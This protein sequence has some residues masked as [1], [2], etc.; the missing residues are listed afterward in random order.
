MNVIWLGHGS[1]G[2]QAAAQNYFRKD[3]SQLTLA[4]CA[5]IAGL[6]QA[7]SRVNPVVA[8]GPA[9]ERMLH[10]LR[11]MERQ[12]WIS[13]AELEA[14]SAEELRIAP[15]RDLLGDHV[16]YYTEMVRQEIVRRFDDAEHGRSWLDRG[17]AVSMAV[18]PALQR[19]ASRALGHALE[20]LARRQGFPGPLGKLDR[21]TFFERNARFV[22]PPG[23]PP[24]PA[25]ARLLG[26]VA[27]VT[28]EAAQIELGS[29][30]AGRLTLA[31][32]KWAGPYTR[33]P[34]GLDKAGRRSAKV[35]F[36]P[37]AGDLTEVLTT[38]D[39]VWV[40][41][42]GGAA[43]TLELA[44]VPVPLVEGAVVSRPHVTGAV[45][46]AVGGW[47][48]DRSQVQRVGALRQTGSVMKPIVYSKAYD[49][50]LPP[51]A[52]FSGAPFREGKYNPTGARTKDD[53][54]VWEALAHSENS[55]SL[56]V[57]QYVLNHTS[58]EDYAA[59]GARLGLTH[60][61]AGY[62]SEVLGTDQTPLGVADV[63][64]TFALGGAAPRSGFIRKVV[65][66]DGRVLLRD[67]L[68]LD[69]RAT[70]RDSLISFV[71]QVGLPPER[72]IS[73]TTA[74]LTSTN[75]ERVVATGTAKRAQVLGV[76]VAGKTGTLPY[77][78]WFAGYTGLR[79]AVVWIGADRRERPLGR[80]EAHGKVYGADTAL[81]AWI[82]LMQR[83]DQDRSARE[84]TDGP[85]ADVRFLRIDPQTGL[86]A[87]SGGRPIPHR[88]GTEPTDFAP[89]PGGAQGLQELEMEF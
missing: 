69:P 19:V 53:M 55:V 54:L 46:V 61:L 67:V 10:V 58:R 44:L 77:D 17:L 4:E 87:R 76:P 20:D 52:L 13:A 18:E 21:Q 48:F 78:V 84:L 2:V 25:G 31:S 71:D 43:R 5:M 85:P 28:R 39:V 70:T 15:L 50:G 56:R 68:P 73:A 83:S 40:E 32:A 82:E 14:A 24:P 41:S 51:S 11:G 8:P 34:E 86:L 57:L 49:L 66:R 45:D 38:G 75:L 89:E 65:D 9:R 59:W 30:L 6:P 62:P 79:T 60:P 64:A 36:K 74:Y 23:A 72:R 3:V 37:R 88:R 42:K 63:F 29:E 81:P 33:L 12:G 35:S 16:P 7:P 27:S 22:P 47:D 1:Y 80:S 26:R